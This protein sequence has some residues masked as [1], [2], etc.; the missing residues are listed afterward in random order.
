MECKSQSAPVVGQ[1]QL[2]WSSTESFLPHPE[3]LCARSLNDDLPHGIIC[4]MILQYSTY[5]G[6]RRQQKRCN[7]NFKI[8]H[9]KKETAPEASSSVPSTWS[10][11]KIAALEKAG[12]GAS[13]GLG[14]SE[15][16]SEEWPLKFQQGC[17]LPSAEF[18]CCFQAGSVSI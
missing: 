18:Y 9:R 13:A 8:E 1:D 6:S 11:D 4:S 14:V 15:Q 7:K 3:A 10:Q 17:R 16:R 5:G 12:A 2:A